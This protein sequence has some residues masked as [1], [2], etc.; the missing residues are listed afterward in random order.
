MAQIQFSLIKKVKTGRP[1]H[2]LPPTSL[3]P[4]AS[5]ICIISSIPPQS[6]RHTFTIIRKIFKTNSSFHVKLR[7]TGKVQF[8]FFRR[9]LLVLQVRN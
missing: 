6:G 2:S 1:E 7:T 3:R 5:H 8:L 9:F 4:K